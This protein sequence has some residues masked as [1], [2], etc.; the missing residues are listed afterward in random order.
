MIFLNVIWCCTNVCVINYYDNKCM[1]LLM[2]IH[3][4]LCLIDHPLKWLVSLSLSTKHIFV[5]SKKN[6]PYLLI[7]A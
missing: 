6:Y 1:Q 2:N 3:R 5:N 4:K 7:C